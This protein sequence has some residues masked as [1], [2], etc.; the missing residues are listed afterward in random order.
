MTFAAP[1][2]PVGAAIGTFEL[3]FQ[4]RKLANLDVFSK[5]DAYVQVLQKEPDTGRML[6]L[7]RTEVV[8]DS[9]N[10]DFITCVRVPYLFE[11]VQTLVFR[12]LDHDGATSEL[13][14][15]ASCTLTD[16]VLSPTR[17][18]AAPLIVPPDMRLGRIGAA[19]RGTIIVTGD[20][21][22]GPRS[23]LS[24]QFAASKVDKKDLLGKS[25]PFLVIYRVLDN[26]QLVPACKTE[27]IKNTLDPTWNPVVATSNILYGSNPDAFV[28]IQCFDYNKSSPPEFIGSV[29][30]PGRELF[31]PGSWELINA[32]KAAKKKSYKNSGILKLINVKKTEVGNFLDFVNG[33]LHMSVVVG[34]DCTA[35]NGSPGYANSLHYLSPYQPNQ[36]QRAISAVGSVMEPYDSNRQFMAFAYGGQLPQHSVVNHCFA[37]NGNDNYP[38]VVGG[39]AG[40]LTMYGN[41]MPAVKLSG[42]T[43]FAPIINRAASFADNARRQGAG[44]LQYFVL[45]MLTDGVYQDRQDTIDAIVAASALPMSIIIIGIGNADFD[46][47]EELDA[48]V[49]PLVSSRGVRMSRD[50]VQFVPF[51]DFESRPLGALSGEVLRELPGQVEKYYALVGVKPPK[52]APITRLGSVELTAAAAASYSASAPAAE[53]HQR[54]ASSSSAASSEALPS[55]EHALAAAA[56]TITL[57]DAS[58]DDEGGSPRHKQQP[59]LNHATSQYPDLFHN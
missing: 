42:P 26:L 8:Q 7:G 39:A 12:V 28:E 20:D 46:A 19:P 55:Y 27:V 53:Q 51:R 17:Q 45:L 31:Q 3:R 43:L 32:R 1:S 52:A 6:Q 58:S 54:A 50:I 41:V 34:I 47:M 44:A 14:G 33:G 56:A 22:S 30:M 57:D 18:F 13:V 2:P 40:L 59:H 16:I 5:T 9:L 29:R 23:E 10:P 15:D 24:M 38:Y 37:L 48:D 25:D 36:Y 4:C 49:K 35:S 11:V 21:I